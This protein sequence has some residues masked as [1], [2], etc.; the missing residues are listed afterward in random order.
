MTWNARATA[1]T[2]TYSTPPPRER[3]LTTEKADGQDLC[4][5]ARQVGGERRTVELR[6]DGE[7]DR[8]LAVRKRV[9]ARPHRRQER[10][11]AELGEDLSEGL[12][13]IEG[14][15]RDEDQPDRVGS[16]RPRD[17]DHR[18]AVG[19]ADQEHRAVNLAG[20]ARDVLGVMRQPAERV[21]R[22]QHRQVVR[23]QILDYWHPERG[24]GKA[25]VN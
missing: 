5:L 12:A 21:R 14:E 17:R 23:L 15:C 2:A 25:A 9:V 4:L 24:V 19:V 7:L 1:P 16:A 18:S 3:I 11:V 10:G 13:L 20:V 22:R 6:P 8:G